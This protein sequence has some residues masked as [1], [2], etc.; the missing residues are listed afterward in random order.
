MSSS[1][2][3]SPVSRFP[4]ASRASTATP[5]AWSPSRRPWFSLG[6]GDQLGA[7]KPGIPPVR[8]A[9]PGVRGLEAGLSKAAG[10]WAGDLGASSMPCWRRARAPPAARG[11]LARPPSLALSWLPCIRRRCA[12]A[13]SAAKAARSAAA[14]AAISS[15]DR[16]WSRKLSAFMAPT[17]PCPWT[18]APRSGGTPRG[19]SPRRGQSVQSAASAAP[20][21]RTLR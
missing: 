20:R 19:N 14:Q 1:S 4:E 18:C 21:P 13:E 11:D 12:A 17:G 6:D 8:D 2:K 15:G 9:T 10:D 7:P 16:S 5:G 3:A